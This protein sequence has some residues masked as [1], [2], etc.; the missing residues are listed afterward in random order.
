[1]GDP[2][3]VLD[4]LWVPEIAQ[5]LVRRVLSGGNH[6]F[7]P[8][9]APPVQIGANA[10]VV[11]FGDWG[12]AL[13]GAQDVATQ[14]RKWLL[15]A[16]SQGRDAH[17]VHL[18]DVYY[19][20][21]PAECNSRVLADGMWPV[22]PE[23]AGEMGSFA[24]AGNHDMYSGGYGY[25][26]V[27]LADDRFRRQRTPDGRPTSFFDLVNDDWRIMGLD[28]GYGDN[29]VWHGDWGKLQD[30]Q[31][32]HVN[33]MAAADDGRSLLLLSH[34]QFVT[35]YDKSGVGPTLER[36]LKPAL[37]SGRIGAW[38]WGHE[39]RC[40]RFEPWGNVGYPC[41]LGHA[42]MPVTTHPKDAPVPK[43]GAWEWRGQYESGG[44][45]WLIFG[46]AV[47]DFNGPTIDVTY[48]DQYGN[49]GTREQIPL[50]PAP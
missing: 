39:H 16:R 24:L 36:K 32:D 21:E 15:E 38:F 42:G 26:D 20:G 7:N 13:P 3:T 45:A 43:P 2:F 19:A 14:A 50:P 8:Q 34:H 46:F 23:E 41:C 18:G 48:V 5:A 33:Q 29:V 44:D 17:A 40:M 49:A 37:D 22:K 12:T 28:T 30:P 9:P 35:V 25:Y 10:R 4:P 47:L 31:G 27:V 1:M 6:A 11:L